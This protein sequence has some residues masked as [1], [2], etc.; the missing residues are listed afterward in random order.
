MKDN[1]PQ[2]LSRTL[3]SSLHRMSWKSLHVSSRRSSSSTVWRSQSWFNPSPV[4]ELLS[5]F[6]YFAITTNI[7]VHNLVCVYFCYVADV[8]SRQIP[9]SGIA[10]LTGKCV[11]SSAWFCQVSLQRCC[12]NLQECKRKSAWEDLFSHRLTNRICGH[13]LIFVSPI[14]GKWYVSVALN[15]I[16]PWWMNL[17]TFCVFED[18]V[19]ELSVHVFF[20][21]FLSIFKSSLYNRNISPLVNVVNIFFQFTGR[22]H[23]LTLFMVGFLMQFL[24]IVG[25]FLHCWWECKLIQPLWR[26]V[27]RFLKKLKIELP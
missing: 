14:G 21:I 19:C 24:K 12:T 18:F 7:A 8:S 2:K 23:L 11:C 16:S 4:Y 1:M 15:C 22:E 25:N 5:S 6:Q 3:L 10:A 13:I 27:W 9:R 17:D 26:T 20:P